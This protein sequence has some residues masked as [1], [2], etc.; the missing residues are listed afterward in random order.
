MT[1]SENKTS[2]N[3]KC[4]KVENDCTNRAKRNKKIFI[5]SDCVPS[6]LSSKLHTNDDDSTTVKSH[7]KYLDLSKG[8]HL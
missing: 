6:V 5:A 8:L 3:F 1:I 2:V 7:M 4:I